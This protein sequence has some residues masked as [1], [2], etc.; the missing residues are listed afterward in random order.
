MSPEEFHVTYLL[1]FIIFS[2]LLHFFL[3]SLQ[4]FSL[5]FS[6]VYFLFLFPSKQVIALLNISKSHFAFDFDLSFSRSR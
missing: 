3:L 2:I 1:I 4:F 5:V 6:F